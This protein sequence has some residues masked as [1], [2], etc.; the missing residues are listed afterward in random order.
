MPL[1]SPPDTRQI[2]AGFP[3]GGEV[4]KGGIAPFTPGTRALLA[5]SSVLHFTAE[6]VIVGYYTLNRSLVSM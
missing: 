6:S 4:P 1:C 5:K 3:L 2:P